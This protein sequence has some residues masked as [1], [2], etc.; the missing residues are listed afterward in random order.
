MAFV[1]PFII[2]LVSGAV[3]VLLSLFGAKSKP[4]IRGWI[5]LKPSAMHWAAAALGTLLCLFM[6]YIR[7]FVGSSRADAETQMTILTWLIVAFGAG[8]I[9]TAVSMHALRR[10]AVHWRGTRI[11]FSG[12]SGLEQRDFGDVVGVRSNIW[13]QVVLTF[14]DGRFLRIDPYATGAENLLERIMKSQSPS[15]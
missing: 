1:K 15:D 14:M 10:R 5:Y 7:L 9:A 4:D 3:V 13:G 2:L 6:A 8:S 12:P 11:S